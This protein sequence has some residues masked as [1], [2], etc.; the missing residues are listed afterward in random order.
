VA[1][2]LTS[3]AEIA[4]VQVYVVLPENHPVARKEH[5]L[6]VVDSGVL[7]HGAQKNGTFDM[8]HF[9]VGAIQIGLIAAGPSDAGAGIVPGRL[10]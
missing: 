5:V 8:C 4:L 7:A 3:L 10:T 9:Q 6:F 1:A 2:Y